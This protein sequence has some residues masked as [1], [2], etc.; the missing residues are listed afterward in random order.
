MIRIYDCSNSS[1]R[2]STR[3]F[4]G[5]VRNEFV[6]LLHK[7]APNYGCVF[8]D[9][10]DCAD[11][12]FTNDIFPSYVRN[13]SIPLV[14]RMDGVFWQ[15]KL[16][17]R[18]RP[19]IESAT[20]ADRVIF[21]SEYSRDSFHAYFPIEFDKLKYTVATHWTDPTDYPKVT[22]KCDAPTQ[23]VAM[24][25]DWKRPE[26]RYDELLTFANRYPVY[27]HLIGRADVPDHP[28][29]IKYGYLGDPID[30]HRVMSMGH[31]FVNLT[32]RDAATKTVCTAMNCGL[33]VLFAGSG[34]VGEL[35]QSGGSCIDEYSVFDIL[36]YIPCIESDSMDRG[37]QLFKQNYQIYVDT[38]R[39]FDGVR[40]LDYALNAYFSE[41]KN[42]VGVL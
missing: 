3:G 42:V 36:D 9:V 33:P 7:Y 10:I 41:I 13:K 6:E 22:I 15:Q 11:V 21:I 17:A 39:Q 20:I 31:A 38:L 32:C 2:P 25:T 34:G 35:V 29:I 18:N 26:K 40:Q 16:F 19:F 23:Y 30:I 5:P 37:Y 8:I 28:R 14:K 1:E 4:G 27:I 12:I 24:A